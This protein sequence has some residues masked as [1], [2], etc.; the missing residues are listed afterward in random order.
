FAFENSATPDLI[1]ATSQRSTLFNQ[2]FAPGQAIFSTWNSFTQ[3]HNTLS[4]T[5]MA[6]PFVAGT[7]ALMQQA[8][9]AFGGR[10]LIPQEVITLLHTSA[11]HI[12][13]ANIT[14]N[15]RVPATDFSDRQDLP[16][17]GLT[18][19]RVNVDRAIQQTKQLVQQ[20]GLTVDSN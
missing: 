19:D 15:G 18:F 8:A 6:S 2:V 14:T 12:V 9:F 20:G 13:D 1:A 3:L 5:S 10:Y 4:G 17:T 16:E 11:D 7:I